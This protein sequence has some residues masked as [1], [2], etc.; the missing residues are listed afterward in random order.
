MTP[1]NYIESVASGV[2]DA[3]LRSRLREE[4]ADHWEDHCERQS[5]PDMPKRILGNETLIAYQTNAV[6]MPGMFGKDV[7]LSVIYGAFTLVLFVM[8]SSFLSLDLENVSAT[9]KWFTVA[10]GV[11]GILFWGS[12]AWYAYLALQRRFIIRYGQSV[13]RT[14]LLAIAAVAPC[15]IM[16]VEAFLSSFN[17]FAANAPYSISWQL[18]SSLLALAILCGAFLHAGRM[19]SKRMAD[20]DRILARSRRNVPLVI[21]AAVIA[22]ASMLIATSDLSGENFELLAVAGM[23]FTMPLLIL[24]LFWG[25]VANAIGFLLAIV[26]IPVIYGYWATVLAALLIGAAVPLAQLA[27]RRPVPSLMQFVASI[28]IPLAIILPAVPQDIPAIDWNDPAVWSWDALEQRQLNVVYPWTASLMRRN[29]GMNVGY[30]AFLSDGKIAVAQ[31]GGSSYVVTRQGTTR[32]RT[33]AEIL[34]AMKDG[35]KGLYA[36]VPAGFTCDARPVEEFFDTHG[37]TTSPFGMFGR[38][39]ASLEY[40]GVQIATIRNG[41][42]ID[43]DVSGDGLLAVTISM[44]SYDP[45]Y[46]YVVDISRR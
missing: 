14:L 39:C 34:S 5:V 26:G 30:G 13:R 20:A 9:T 45:T 7:A 2:T 1:R 32:I 3:E 29:D 18:V 43:L 36:D 38:Q 11:F 25:L 24:Y 16:G 31:G 17:A 37:G 21:A 28:V 10:A 4:L 44:G 40:K 46:V 33:A 35:G 8:L 19:V 41:S 15:T 27:F 12:V 23:P 22:G 42:L 6:A